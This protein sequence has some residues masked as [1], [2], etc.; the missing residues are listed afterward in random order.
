MRRV[1]SNVALSYSRLAVNYFPLVKCSMPVER[2]G[3]RERMS[4]LLGTWLQNIL[5]NLLLETSE[6]TALDSSVV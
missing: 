1:A 2:C 3:T 5:R 4:R 6:T